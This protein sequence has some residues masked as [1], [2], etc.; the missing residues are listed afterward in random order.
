[1]ATTKARAGIGSWGQL[2]FPNDP[3]SQNSTDWVACGLPRK[4]KKLVTD[5]K[6][7][8][9][10]TPTK[11][12]WVGASWWRERDTRKTAPIA[13]RAPRM[14]PKETAQIPS[15]AKA[16]NR[17]T[18]VAPTLAPEEIPSGRGAAQAL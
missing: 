14:L 15:E 1:M 4:I 9:S 16:P 10:T 13:P 7:A 2:A 18:A 6:S 5:S 8:E 17:S 12:S 3:S 11:M